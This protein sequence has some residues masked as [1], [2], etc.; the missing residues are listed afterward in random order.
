MIEFLQKEKE[1][2]T[3]EFI[4]YGIVL[5]RVVPLS[6]SVLLA[7]Y[8]LTDDL[9]SERMM[10]FIPYL[11]IIFVIVLMLFSLLTYSADLSRRIYEKAINKLYSGELCVRFKDMHNVFFSHDNSTKYSFEVFAMSTITFG[12]VLF[13][14]VL[15][16]L[17]AL[18]ILGNEV[19]FW[20]YLIA[21]ILLPIIVFISFG[22][23]VS[24]LTKKSKDKE[25]E[26]LQFL[27]GS[28][29]KS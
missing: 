29:N 19:Y 7:A 8:L 23:L 28:T 18:K 21:I 14:Y 27:E 16:A 22:S 2:C 3:H 13:F 4:T 12:L 10:L 26:V 5:F 9:A 25:L 11:V 6:A 15:S 24:R 17:E 1:N 20:F